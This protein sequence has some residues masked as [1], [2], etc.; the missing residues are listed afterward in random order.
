MNA[1]ALHIK[2][3]IPGLREITTQTRATLG[4][5]ENVRELGSGQGNRRHYW[6]PL[7]AKPVRQKGRKPLRPVSQVTPPAKTS[8]LKAVQFIKRMPNWGENKGKLASPE[9]VANILEGIEKK[10]YPEGDINKETTFADVLYAPVPGQYF[11]YA[12]FMSL[13]PERQ[14]FDQEGTPKIAHLMSAVALVNYYQEENQ[15]ENAIK[16]LTT[17][18]DSVSELIELM[19]TEITCE[20]HFMRDWFYDEMISEGFI[21]CSEGF[22]LFLTYLDGDGDDPWPDTVIAFL[23]GQSSIVSLLLQFFDDDPIGQEL[24]SALTP[25]DQQI[26]SPTNID[27]VIEVYRATDEGRRVPL[28][29]LCLENEETGP[30]V[31][32]KKEMPD[33]ADQFDHQEIVTYAGNYQTLSLTCADDL[34]YVKRWEAGFSDMLSKIPFIVCDDQ[35]FCNEEIIA[36]DAKKFVDDLLRVF[37][38]SGERAGA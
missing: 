2:D 31:D 6:N 21:D 19:V 24:F 15:Q 3:Q 8:C 17:P 18:L 23:E 30:W 22:P 35:G 12:D 34:R 7:K 28:N 33:Y 26:L 9:V 14:L 36:D 37:K 5:F 1:F 27:K 4:D 25:E 13:Y 11:P 29:Y 20:D 10:I 32:A 16:I 38:S